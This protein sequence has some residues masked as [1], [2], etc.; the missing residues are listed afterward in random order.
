M[1]ERVG[2]VQLVFFFCFWIVVR[3]EIS[4]YHSEGKKLRLQRAVDWH[5]AS[6]GEVKI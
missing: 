4:L 3:E 1:G 6:E 2:Y 5:G